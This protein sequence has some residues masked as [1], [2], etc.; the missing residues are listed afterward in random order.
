MSERAVGSGAV[1]ELRSV[2]W[3]AHGRAGRL[4]DAV[5]ALRLSPRF[6]GKR[7]MNMD[8]TQGCIVS[9]RCVGTLRRNAVSERG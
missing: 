3:H 7:L 6:V 1:A 8:M 5:L 9:E 4:Q 2:R